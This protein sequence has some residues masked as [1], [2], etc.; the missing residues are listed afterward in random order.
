MFIAGHQARR[1]GCARS[2]DPSSQVAF[3]EGVKGSVREAVS[4]VCDQLIHNS[5]I[6]WH[7]GEVLSIISP[8]VSTTLGSVF[9]WSA[10]FIW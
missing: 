7:Q 6:G 9:L 4:G 5:W 1:T 2:K 10:V 8:W 3:G